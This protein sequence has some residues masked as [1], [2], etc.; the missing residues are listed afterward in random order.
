MRADGITSAAAICLAPQNSRTS[1]GLYRRAAFAEAGDAIQIEFVEGWAEHPLLAKAFADNLVPLRKQLSA[2]LGAEIPVL[3]TA[4]SVPCRTIQ[5]PPRCPSRNASRTRED[6]LAGRR[7]RNSRPLRS[8]RQ[9]YRPPRRGAG[10][11]R[12]LAVVLRLSK[13]GPIRRPVDRPHRRSYPHR[14]ESGWP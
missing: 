13:P 11:T 10:G 1:V 4:H 12:R 6:L 2:E 8:R 7:P 3:F 5:T 9:E 14:N